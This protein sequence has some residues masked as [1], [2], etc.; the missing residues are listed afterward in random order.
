ML[1]CSPVTAAEAFFE[2]GQGPT[3]GASPVLPLTTGTD[4]PSSAV[5]GMVAGYLPINL[6]RK[7]T[8]TA[9]FDA[10][11]ACLSL[12]NGASLRSIKRAHVH[13]TQVRRN[14]LS[15]LFTSGRHS[16][17]RAAALQSSASITVGFQEVRAAHN[18]RAGDV[19][20]A[21]GTSRGKFVVDAIARSAASSVRPRDALGHDSRFH[22]TPPGLPG[23]FLF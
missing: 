1:E 5:L 13:L 4:L 2:G 21:D 23:K 7:Y 15:P 8:A 6:A 3:L 16:A 18:Y 19:R 11:Q 14:L 20:D 17:S 9:T 10:T 22:C 12:D